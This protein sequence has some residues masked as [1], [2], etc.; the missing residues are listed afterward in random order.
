MMHLL[1]LKKKINYTTYKK[2]KTCSGSGAKPGS[3]PSVCSYCSGQG[4]VKDLVKDFSL[5]NKLVLSVVE[6]EK[7][8]L[9]H[10]INAVE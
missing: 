4:R 3:K 2:C 9:I 1:V 10:V 6:K 7:K 5:F 8:L